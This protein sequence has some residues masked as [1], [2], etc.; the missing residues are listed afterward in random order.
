MEEGA[1]EKL[2]SLTLQCKGQGCH[3]EEKKAVRGTTAQ[4]SMSDGES[5]VSCQHSSGG[6]NQQPTDHSGVWGRL[7]LDEGSLGAVQ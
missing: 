2:S 1:T 4:S 6:V 5:E 3:R 7:G